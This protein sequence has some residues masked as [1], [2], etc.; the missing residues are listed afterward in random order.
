MQER[1]GRRQSDGRDMLQMITALREENKQL[2]RLARLGYQFPTGSNTRRHSRKSNR[3]KRGNHEH[4]SRYASRS[5]RSFSLSKS[6]GHESH[7]AFSKS[8]SKRK[9]TELFGE[10]ST[11]R[12]QKAINEHDTHPISQYV[13]I[14]D[15]SD[16]SYARKL[17]KLLAE[18]EGKAKHPD[19]LRRIR[20]EIRDLIDR[21]NPSDPKHTD[22]AK[23]LEG[24]I[25]TSNGIESVG[26]A[27]SPQNRENN[28]HSN[29][30]YSDTNTIVEGQEPIDNKPEELNPFEVYYEKL[31][32][33][34]AVKHRIK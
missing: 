12:I 18:S 10:T 28:G 24:L 30:Y 31:R 26:R 27:S 3:R 22:I 14:L 19:G 17:K 16:P 4:R 15:P 20:K 11:K 6:L 25:A 1:G 23:K 13:I 7:D 34:T 9:H 29:G 8:S 5:G 33:E 32:C 2:R 21:L